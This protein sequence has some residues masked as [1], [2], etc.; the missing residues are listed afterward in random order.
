MGITPS[1]RDKFIAQA[2][3]LR[4][5]VIKGRIYGFGLSGGRI[6]STTLSPEHSDADGHTS[7]S[8]STRSDQM[9]RTRGDEEVGGPKSGW[10]GRAVFPTSVSAPTSVGDLHSSSSTL[11]R[12]SVRKLTNG[13][14]RVRG[15]VASYERSAG[16]DSNSSSSQSDGS[17]LSDVPE[18]ESEDRSF[19][20]DE[21]SGPSTAW[22]FSSEHSDVDSGMSAK[23]DDLIYEVVAT[24]GPRRDAIPV[25]EHHQ[26]LHSADARTSTG[27]GP[28]SIDSEA[29]ESHHADL[30]GPALSLAHSSSPP[31]YYDDRSPPTVGDSD[32]ELIER[33]GAAFLQKTEEH[34]PVTVVPTA[35]LSLAIPD[36]PLHATAEPVAEEELSMEE[37][38]KRM[39]PEEEEEEA[40]GHPWLDD[41][42]IG[43]TA[44]RITHHS[45]EKIL[46]MAPSLGSSPLM[47]RSPAALS[48][49]FAPPE[50]E[51][52]F[53]G[54]PA[55]VVDI[56]PVAQEAPATAAR[57]LVEQSVWTETPEEGEIIEVAQSI[58]A[59]TADSLEFSSMLQ[60]FR[61]RLEAVE[62]RLDELE[63]REAA[64]TQEELHTR[65]ELDKGNTGGGIFLGE[66][67]KQAIFPAGSGHVAQEI[68]PTVH[69]SV[70]EPSEDSKPITH[71]KSAM[72][73]RI[74][75]SKNVVDDIPA[76]L[77]DYVLGASLG[78][79]VILVQFVF[80]R[81]V[82]RR[83]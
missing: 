77:A 25:E 82:A 2:H 47:T 83:S 72:N 20:G 11:S 34:G 18:R 28:I 42:I 22:D 14:M 52:S 58:A 5:K 3:V 55:P 49:L 68:V 61:E 36:D 1:W 24:L 9:S 60:V 30:A 48:S 56:V 29:E 78:V 33:I 40:S 45:S 15:M 8:V 38:L 27:D 13:G 46:R 21:N 66:V 43:Q 73:P 53:P 65:L 51:V 35:H 64:R 80:R 54:E 4:Q 31:G 79:V 50:P 70:V 69:T 67:E 7:R 19:S 6:S 23:D 26:L 32:T 57:V 37:L 17:K 63:T 16:S 71:P 76:G 12:Q 44:R 59:V 81:F 74:W 62:R 10:I 39:G 75:D 41:D